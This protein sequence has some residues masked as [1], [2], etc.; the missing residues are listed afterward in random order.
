MRWFRCAIDAYVTSP[1]QVTEDCVPFR[2]HESKLWNDAES[3][4][5]C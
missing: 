5:V 2:E 3:E 1:N 4:G